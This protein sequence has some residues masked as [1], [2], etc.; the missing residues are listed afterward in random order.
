MFSVLY[1]YE[2]YLRPGKVYARRQQVEVFHAGFYHGVRDRH[3]VYHDVIQRVFYF[4]FGKPESAR[5]V[6]LRVEVYDK[7]FVAFCRKVRGE[8]NAG[9]GFSYA[10]LL[11]GK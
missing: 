4:A 7:N 10:A 6:A 2:F 3:V 8:V 11:V 1:V 9:G 5:R